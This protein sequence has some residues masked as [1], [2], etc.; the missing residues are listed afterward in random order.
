MALQTPHD[1]VFSAAAKTYLC[2]GH[3]LEAVDAP[4]GYPTPEGPAVDTRTLAKGIILVTVDDL[5][6]NDY[7]TVRPGRVKVAVLQN[8]QSLW[9]SPHYAG[10]PGYS[11]SFLQATHCTETDLITLMRRLLPRTEDPLRDLLD[12]VPL[13]FQLAGILTCAVPAR[14][15]HSWDPEWLHYLVES[16]MPEVSEAWERAWSRPDRPLIE[17][18][19][20]AAVT[21]PLSADSEDRVRE[22]D[23]SVR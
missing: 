16:W 7:I 2:A 18:S 10:A 19:V 17:R 23:H 3:L 13:E 5:E 21:S 4:A 14:Q 6:R 22:Y 15:G 11:A 9:V 12:A 1:V 8:V 20:M